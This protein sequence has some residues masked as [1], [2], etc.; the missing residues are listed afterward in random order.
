MH[1]GEVSDE[2]I[3]AF[4]VDVFFPR[5]GWVCFRSSAMP[6]FGLESCGEVE[7]INGLGLRLVGR[8]GGGR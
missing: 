5:D 4:E 6:L 7:G 1:I 8:G 2:D 3:W